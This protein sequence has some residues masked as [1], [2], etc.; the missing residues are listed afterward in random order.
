M[1]RF[2][3][4]VVVVIAGT[5]VTIGLGF[6]AGWLLIP[7]LGPD[8]LPQSTRLEGS[9]A[10][11]VASG[12]I[13]GRFV[14]DQ[15]LTAEVGDTQGGTAEAIDLGITYAGSST[16]LGVHAQDASVGEPLTGSDLAV[17]VVLNGEQF[18]VPADAC[19][20]E[21]QQLRYVV[22]RP[23]AAV[24]AGPPRGVPLPAFAGRIDCQGLTAVDSN[25]VVNLT[26]VFRVDPAS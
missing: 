14:L 19:V 2:V 18:E 21:L 13:A 26:G 7:R 6:A 12:D 9:T 1:G 22:L 5:A 16:R 8:G 24:Q 23:L 10:M 17:E 3:K 4:D 25:R 15:P 20:V 11:L